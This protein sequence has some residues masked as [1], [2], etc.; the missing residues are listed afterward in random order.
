MKEKLM[1]S[2]GYFIA[3]LTVGIYLITSFIFIDSLQINLLTIIVNSGLLFAG[4]VICNSALLQQGLLNGH[5]SEIFKETLRAHIEQRKKIFPRLKYLQTWLDN[6]YYKLLKLGRMGY[7]NSAGY[8][9]EEVFSETGKFN[10]EFKIKKP[11]KREGEEWKLYKQQVRYI[12]KAK[13]YKITR[14]TV[15]SVLQ[16]EA[17]PDPNDFGISEKKYVAKQNTMSVVSRLVF[18]VLLQSVT[19]DFYGFNLANFLVQLMSIASVLI[20][21]FYSMF[22]AYTFVVKTYREQV[23][24]KISKLEEF[25]N[26]DLSELL[27][28]EER[29][30]ELRTE[31]PR[32]SQSDM[33]EEIYTTKEHREESNIQSE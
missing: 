30:V 26:A 19:F 33:V 10:K 7:V 11:D 21:A 29:E 20:G 13:K 27:N 2:T 3:L 28:K 16:I 24:D 5:N 32:E 4:A 14:L 15:S 17:S 23:K 22:G 1:K 6:D 8:D 31:I 18:S 12:N 9:Y 25:E